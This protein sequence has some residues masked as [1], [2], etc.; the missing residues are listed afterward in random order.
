MRSST[1]MALFASAVFAQDESATLINF[2]MTDSTLTVLDSDASATTY[3]KNC[4]SDNAGISAV[5]SDLRRS[6]YRFPGNIVLT[7]HSF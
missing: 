2:F 4:P 3:R 5:P 7:V 1:Y 6:R